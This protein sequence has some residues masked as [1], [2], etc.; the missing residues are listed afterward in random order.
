MYNNR[1]QHLEEAH[2][3][4]NKRID[5]MTKTGI[6]EDRQIEELKKERLILKDKIAILK[7]SQTTEVDI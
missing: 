2:K 6:Y 5:N 7:Q 3:A 1:I 4:L